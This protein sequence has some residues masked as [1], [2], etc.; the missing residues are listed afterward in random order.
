M[1][2]EGERI[3]LV[4]DDRHTLISLGRLL[5]RD[6]F[7]V[8]RYADGRMALAAFG[9]QPPDLAVMDIWMPRI[10]GLCLMRRVRRRSRL[11]VIFLTGCDGEAAEA[12]ALRLGADDFLR[13]PVSVPLLSLRIR[14]VLRRHV[15]EGDMLVRG[16]LDLDRARRLARWKGAPVPLTAREFAILDRLASHPGHV[17]TREDLLDSSGAG[18]VER[19][20]DSHIKR[21]RR[22]FCA[23]D[24]AFAAI[25]TL[26][27]GGY[28]FNSG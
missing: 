12:D 19:A 5:E 13:K 27:G 26:Y 7:V 9:R 25:R 8:E 24:P 4:D 23:V 28:R 20:I 6:G 2:A 14:A 15:P 16:S 18:G 21:M 10:D 3:A 1:A 17:R 11:P 22:K